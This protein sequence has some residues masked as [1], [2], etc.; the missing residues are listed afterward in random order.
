M[1]LIETIVTYD[2]KCT[3]SDLFK[4]CNETI[5]RELQVLHGYIIGGYNR[6][7]ISYAYDTY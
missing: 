5:L 1:G 3:F 2:S 7:N 4:I 6:N